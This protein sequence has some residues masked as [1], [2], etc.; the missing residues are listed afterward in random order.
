MSYVVFAR[1]YRPQDF[2]EIV[3]QAF[4]ATTLKNAI[5]TD[6]IAHAYLFDGPRGI[7]KTSTARIFAKA[8][9]CKDGPTVKPCQECISCKE[10]TNGISMDVI[11]IDGASNRG[12]DEIR[13][14][15][16]NVKF[17]AIHG[18]YKIYI[19]DEV[20]M[21][22]QE[23]FNALLK[24]LE[25]PP[26]HVKF[27][28][29]TTQPHKV[30]PTILSRCQRFDFKRIP[31]NKI[32]SKLKEIVKK[33]KFDASDDVLLHIARAADGSL[34]DAETVLDQLGSF[35]KGKVKKEAVSEILGTIGEEKIFS[36]TEAIIKKD[37]KSALMLVDSLLSEGKD[38]VQFTSNLIEHTRNLLVAK[39]GKDLE[40]LIDLPL[41]S[42][43]RITAQ[44]RNFTIGD[45]L[46]I[47]YLLTNTRESIK[48]SDSARI[49]LETALI[50]LTNRA[51]V[52]PLEEILDRI[53]DLEE[54]LGR[55]GKEPPVNSANS[56]N[57]TNLIDTASIAEPEEKIPPVT[58]VGT[59]E[60]NAVWMNL[61][62]MMR[63]KK[64]SVATYLL[65]GKVHSMEG[66]VFTIGFPSNYSFHKESLE[67]I[68]NKSLIE[69]T[70]KGILNR[71]VRIKFI[72][73]NQPEEPKAS[74]TKEDIHV[75]QRREEITDP[76]IQ[77]A[78]R[79]FKGKIVAER[80]TQRG[81]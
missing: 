79:T 73:F 59:D 42:I 35:C 12:I 61:L 48:R 69:D 56:T 33:E 37:T 17:G 13:N 43:E 15:R 23:A 14:L 21:L 68:E 24:T 50:K 6:R 77:S 64:M 2:D 16:E 81:K 20:H 7:G 9:N 11:E 39:V 63:D 34:R 36:V 80:K 72:T 57:S 38:L 29:A 40:A 52:K 78:I 5:Q 3:G 62:K 70:L 8:L 60:I 41:H 53:S 1:R 66:G 76:I 51:E 54:R 19:I 44:S 55:E 4:I 71:D 65:E 32:I 31:T 28:F 22:T 46:Y 74:A 47:V 58:N 18:K 49:P 30:P 75:P 26:A 10:I 27:I 45:L 67:H 25:E